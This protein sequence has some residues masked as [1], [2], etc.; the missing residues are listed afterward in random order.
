MEE[1]TKI[2]HDLD[3][4]V[5]NRTLEI[6]CVKKSINYICLKAKNAFSKFFFCKLEQQELMWGVPQPECV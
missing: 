5:Y 3:D 1:C 4:R 6:V 2:A